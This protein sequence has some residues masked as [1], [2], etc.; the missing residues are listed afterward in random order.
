MLNNK[1][2]QSFLYKSL[3]VIKIIPFE[4]LIPQTKPPET[5]RVCPVT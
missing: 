1:K 2:F 3:F 4:V 5:S